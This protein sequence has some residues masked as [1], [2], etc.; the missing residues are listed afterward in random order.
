MPKALLGSYERAWLLCV[1]PPLLGFHRVLDALHAVRGCRSLIRA[2]CI[3][4]QEPHQVVV[5]GPAML[6]REEIGLQTLGTV[7]RGAAKRF[8]QRRESGRRVTDA[9]LIVTGSE[10]RRLSEFGLRSLCWPRPCATC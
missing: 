4:S 7:L 9:T 10:V 2:S 1:P 5:T 3:S 8:G 6:E